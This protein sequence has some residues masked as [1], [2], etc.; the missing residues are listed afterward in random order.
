MIPLEENRYEA[1]NKALT[2]FL[3]SKKGK[4]FMTNYV[5]EQADLKKK[6][7]AV[8]LAL[9][10]H[11]A[12]NDTNFATHIKRVVKENRAKIKLC[13][14][15]DFGYER[16]AQGELCEINPT[17]QFHVLWNY[18]EKY[19]KDT[20]AKAKDKTFLAECYTIGDY[21]MQLFQGQGCFWRIYRKGRRYFQI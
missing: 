8:L 17:T 3:S 19:G 1:S 9:K 20:Y 12:E 11:F 16:N 14:E 18:F 15:K 10:K 2:K 4:D 13:N 21:T 6:K 7:N 5:K